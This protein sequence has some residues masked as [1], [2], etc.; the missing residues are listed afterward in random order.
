MRLSS[1]ARCWRRRGRASRGAGEVLL[2]GVTGTGARRRL[3]GLEAVRL[4]GCRGGDVYPLWQTSGTRA[5]ATA[6]ARCAVA[7]FGFITWAGALTPVARRPS[8][9]AEQQHFART[10]RPLVRA[11]RVSDR[12][13]D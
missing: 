11:A 9:A 1:F 4:L 5:R 3:E 2:L 12:C 7:R 10:A 8:R 13:A 6:P